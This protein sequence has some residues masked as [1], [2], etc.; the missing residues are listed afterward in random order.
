M[1]CAQWLFVG[2]QCFGVDYALEFNIYGYNLH[3]DINDEEELGRY[4]VDEVYFEDI[5]TGSDL[6][7]YIDYEKFGRDIAI[8]TDG[9][10]TDYG[11][12]ERV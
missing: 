1:P 3:T 11:F 5:K 6:Y 10:F 4:Y 2:S 12:I 7:D 9:G 8:N